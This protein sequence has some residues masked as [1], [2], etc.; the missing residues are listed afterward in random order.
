[1]TRAIAHLRLPALPCWPAGS[2]LVGGAVRD[3]LLGLPVTDYDFAGPNPKAAAHAC[4][5]ATGGTAFPLDEERGHWRVAAGGVVYDFAPLSAS[6]EADLARR[7]YTANALA[8]NRNGAVYGPPAALYDLRYGVLRAVSRQNLHDDP[9]RP[10]RGWRIW[11]GRGLRPEQRTRGWIVSEARRQRFGRQPAAERVR[12]ELNQVLMLPQ[13]SWGFAKLQEL[14]LAAVYLREWAA[15]A[16]V[17]QLGYHHLDVLGH[18]LEALHQLV[19]RFPESSLALRWAALLHDV[20]KPLVRQWDEERGYYRFFGHDELGAAIAGELLR[21]LR[22]PRG[23]VKRVQALV[24]RHMKTPP[25][26]T[27]GRRRRLHRNRRLLPDLL[28]LQI[29]DRAATRGELAAREEGRLDL[30]YQTLAEARDLVVKSEVEPLLNGSQ[31][32]AELGLEPGPLVGVLRRALAEAQALGDVTDRE[33]ALAF[34]R[35]KY[36]TETKGP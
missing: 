29:A 15:G 30:L 23:L 32:I 8:A 2:Y 31:I 16:G 28:M 22:Y 34:V 14:E 25:A 12:E 7:D 11:A 5:G 4:A 13:A 35:W 26:S 20:A 18:E 19:W 6:L 36:E 24:R 21:R 9:L 17:E 10:L 33:E 27:R 3:L 1:V